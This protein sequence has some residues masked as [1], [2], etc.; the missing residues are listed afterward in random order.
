[1]T[2]RLTHRSLLLLGSV[3]LLL[4][5]AGI[6]AGDLLPPQQGPTR[7][8]RRTDRCRATGTTGFTRLP[9]SVLC[10]LRRG[11][12]GSDRRDSRSQSCYHAK[13]GD[14]RDALRRS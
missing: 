12:R 8:L 10:D 7:Q 13:P 6:V 14:T 3:L 11:D 2:K 1:M 4:A 5:A 9:A